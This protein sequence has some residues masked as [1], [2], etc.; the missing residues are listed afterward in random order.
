MKIAA[1][2]LGAFIALQPAPYDAVL[3]KLDAYLAD[4]EPKLSELIAD[5]TMFQE[6]KGEF[7]RIRT[8]DTALLGRVGDR[9]KRLQSEVAFIALPKDS[10]W[11]GFRHVKV[12]NRDALDDDQSLTTSLSVSGVDGART[13]LEAS[14]AHNL[15]LPRTTNLPNLPLE[16]LHR[17]N[18]HRLVARL[19]GYE[20]VRG[21]TAVRVVFHEKVTPTLIRHPDGGDMPSTIRAWI[22][23]VN[24]RL[25]KA[26]VMTFKHPS[27]P[28]SENSVEVDF[29]HEEKLGLLVPKQMK[30]TFPAD[31]GT[32]TSSATYSN[33]RRFTTSARIVPQ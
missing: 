13:L 3:A 1:L 32:G 21:V 28:K 25:L 31:P 11:L 18:R 26:V 10:G 5:E 14:A 6:I 16:F 22:D 30:E 7:S 20:R 19:D 2:A 12:V 9:Q 4:Y 15:G 29:E 23:P 17:R 24:G 27:A 33:Y 8:E